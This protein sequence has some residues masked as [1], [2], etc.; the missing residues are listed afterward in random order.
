MD[1]PNHLPKDSTGTR[2]ESAL[3]V[4][5]AQQLSKWNQTASEAIN[6]CAHD[7]IR[8]RALSQPRLP[9]VCSWDGDLTYVELDA[10]ASRLACYLVSQGIGPEVYVPLC[11]EKS[12]W[13][14]VSMLAVLKAGGAFVHLDPTQPKKRLEYIIQQTGAGLALASTKHAEILAELVAKVFKVHD[15]SINNLV[16]TANLPNI[17][18]SNAAY[19]IFTSGSTGRPKGVVIEH[20]QLCTSSIKGGIAMGFER[21][22]RMLQFASYTFDACILETIITLIFGGCVCIPSEWD[23]MNYLVGSMNKMKVTSAIF[24]PSLLRNIN[25]ESLETLNTMILGGESIP[26]EL[27]KK[28]ATKVKLILAYGPT[29]CTVICLTL[30]TGHSCFHPGDLGQLVAGQA[31]VVDQNDSNQLTLAGDVG[32]LLIEGPLLARGYLNDAEKTRESFIPCPVWFPVSYQQDRPR[33]YRTGDLVKYNGNGTISFVS[34]KD[35]Q[36]KVRG[37]RLEIGE[38][39]CQLRNCFATNED[40]VEVVVELVTLAAKTDSV[41]LVAFIRMAAKAIGYL[42][43]DENMPTVA[44][45][46]E[47]EQHALSS[48]ASDMVKKLSLVLPSYAVPSV[49][50]PLKEIP[51]SISGKTD[52]KR[53]RSLAGQLSMAQLASFTTAGKGSL[54]TEVVPITLV[55]LRLQALWAKTLSLQPGSI[56][57][58]DN[59]LWLGGDSVS[60]IGLVAA[61]RTTGLRLTVETIFRHPILS[62]MAL[63]TSLA[64]N[65]QENGAVM[66]P[67]TLVPIHQDVDRLCAR[68]SIQ[69]ELSQGLIE[70]IYPCSPMQHA[71]MALSIKESGAYVMQFVYSLSSSVDLEKFKAAWQTV[72]S[73]TPTLRTRF[74]EDDS[75]DLLQ[76]V[77]HETLQWN[78]TTDATLNSFL[79]D[80]LKNTMRLGQQMSRYS[81]LKPSEAEDS[82]YQFVW[83][84]HH[85]VLDGWSFPQVIA[86]VEQAYFGQS[87]SRTIGFKSFIQHLSTIDVDAATAFWAAQLTEPPIPQFPQLPSPAFR[88]LGS[89]RLE[90]E[91]S[92]S[93]KPESNITRATILKAAWALLVGMYSNATDIIT[94]MTLSGRTAQV[95]G[96]E[97]II[98][99]T[100]TTVP[101]RVQFTKDQLICDLLQTIQ[102]QY[103]DVL[104]HEQIGLQKISRISTEAKAACAFRSLLVIQWSGEPKSLGLLSG[105]EDMSLSL[106]YPITMECTL[107][108]TESVKIRAMFDDRVLEPRQI[109]RI[110]R[111][112]EHLLQQLSEEN[113]ETKVS[114]ICGICGSDM[115]EVI[116]WNSTVPEAFE[117]CLHHLIDQRTKQQPDGMAICSWDGEMSYGMLDRLSSG[118]AF[119]LIQNEAVGPGVVVPVCFEKSKW[120]VVAMV[121]ALKAGGAVVCLDSS[122]PAS[123]LENILQDLGDDLSK[124]VLTSASNEHIFSG[125]KLVKN[126]IALD[127]D[128]LNS[129]LLEPCISTAVRPM[130]PA[131]VVFTSGSTGR[132][133]GIRIEH[134]AVCTSIREHGAMI[135]LGRHSRVLQFAAH[136]FDIA[137]GDIFATLIHGGCICIPS[138]H[139]RM[140]DLSGAIRSLNANHASLTATVAA[141]LQPEDVSCLKVLVSAG[142]AMTRELMEKW[143]G[144]VDLI[145]MYGPAECTIYCIGHQMS[146]DIDHPSVIGKGVGSVVWIADP[147]DPNSLTPIG[148]VG[149]ILIEGPT[150]ARGYINDKLN[151]QSSFIPAPAWLP[152]RSQ[153]LGQLPRLYRT[154]D[155][156]T[157]NSDGTIS[158]IG[159]NDGQVKL[160]GQRIEVGEIEYNLREI[161]STSADVVVEVVQLHHEKPTLAAFLAVRPHGNIGNGT[162]IVPSSPEELARFHCLTVGLDVN[163]KAALPSYMVPSIF[164]P[165]KRIPLSTSGKIDRKRL[166]I[167]ASELSFEQLAS[168]HVSKN[169]QRPSTILEQCLLSLWQVLLGARE[170]SIEDNF[171]RLGGDSITAMRLV[172]AARNEGL[173]LTVD[174]IFKNP[175]LSELA[176][177]TNNSREKDLP[178]VEPFSLLPSNEVSKLLEEAMAQSKISKE[179]IED[180]YPC[181]RVQDGYTSLQARSQAQCVFLMPP[182]MDSKRF[183]A[184]WEAV[185]ATHAVLRTR[186]IRTSSVYAPNIQVVVKGCLKWCQETSL[187]KYL[188]NDRLDYM[189]F[190]DSINRFCI[191]EEDSSN[192]RFFV[193]TASHTSYDGTSL[194]LLYDEVE[195][196]Y[197]HGVTASLDGLKFNQFIKNTVLV[198][199]A[200]AELFWRTHLAGSKLVSLAHRFYRVPDTHR[201]KSVTTFARDFEVPQCLESEITLTTMIEVAM[202]IVFARHLGCNEVVFAQTRTGRNFPL[203]GVEHLVAP[204]MTRVPRRI[205]IEPDQ[206]IQDVLSRTQR[207]ASDMAPFEP[208]G[209]DNIKTLSEDA[210]AA[211]DSAIGLNIITGP[212]FETAQLGSGID[213]KL[214]WSGHTGNYKPLRLIIRTF[215]GG[216]N[217][218]TTFDHDII[219]PETMNKI[220][221]QFEQAVYQ[222][223]DAGSEQRVGDMRL[224]DDLGEGGQSRC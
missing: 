22:P 87:I 99:P 27:V 62:D 185:A 71:L 199:Q 61:A 93:R 162:D 198:D 3:G 157:Y 152:K 174:K 208:F 200:P 28:W 133:K 155:L 35:N 53:L 21:K 145:N 25:L 129:I 101:F 50:I 26:H 47:A 77:L 31:W 69:F 67:F 91:V 173:S 121:A 89:S 79:L 179:Q 183:R 97:H 13:A 54:G 180:I 201:T 130:D 154:G 49:L 16:G 92:L 109:Q 120:A 189:A 221:R 37:Q 24:T 168:F 197:R 41:I 158:F 104:P 17:S 33:M 103:L 151:T 5:N 116:Q 218:S 14:I 143:A 207:D 64:T 150:L 66:A 127:S 167:L 2:E 81:I 96:I 59:F 19:T 212:N 223:I 12:I 182:S 11:F 115:T 142:E 188:E 52:R 48:L 215:E 119:N 72:V 216:V 95:P 36:V 107:Q 18:P 114:D 202:A 186:I 149:E 9:A 68:V 39:E 177:S 20:Q 10:L 60:A 122:H 118:L 137:F 42:S 146:R 169:G 100:I 171:F 4:Y 94:G 29:E 32:E 144:H 140:N 30:D 128:F 161:L 8:E 172:V 213:L 65:C 209:W 166:R 165:L 211:C 110:F 125:M 76:A 134:T 117:T 132:P 195:H 86:C 176:L 73:Q 153:V 136:T 78:I 108:A 164:I 191:V 194:G 224:N 106:D 83:T 138:S 131:L 43:C 63:H 205:H 75:G 7:L 124:C 193:W 34:R 196:A 70:D 126:T 80:N 163:L 84:V 112:F 58:Q 82:N 178:N 123:R 90:Y 160:R 156:G 56:G 38:V 206:K 1:T 113:P 15:E 190:G 141:Q 111:Q 219:A 40:V 187:E 220:L 98:G 23:R 44:V 148:A 88:P 217:A 175:V 55:E 57:T 135:K 51:L 184:A 170:I 192:K 222:I 6:A 139:D 210:H 105:T 147:N 102:D 159:R 203:P 46:S 181:T 85:S 45:S 74:F 204:T 214:V